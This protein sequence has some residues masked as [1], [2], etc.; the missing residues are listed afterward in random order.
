[1]SLIFLVPIEL[2][3]PGYAWVLFSG[4]NSRFGIAE[5]LALSF[6]ISVSFT[7][8]FTAGLSLVTSHYLSYSVGGSLGLSTIL[9]ILSF[10]HGN[11]FRRPLPK[12]DRTMLPVIATACI[13]VV[14]LTSLFWSSPFYPNTDAYDPIT[15]A[16]VVEGIIDGFGRTLLLHSN[17]AIGLHFVSAVLARLLAVDSL[18]AIRFLLSMVI[19]VSVFLTYFSARSLLGKGNAI[20][21]LIVAA[22]IIPADAIHF[23]RV[24]TF[25]NILADAVVVAMLWLIVSYTTEPNRALGLTLTFLAVAGL[26]VHSSFLMFIA[27]LWVALPVFLISYRRYFKN[28]FK[29][30]LFTTAG[31]FCLFVLLGSFLSASLE[32]I[33][34]GYVASS[35]SPTPV[36]LLL[37]VLVW[38][39]V[40]LAGPLA[41]VSIVAAVVFVVVKQR[42]A[43]W[44]IFGC[45]WFGLLVVAAFI[46]PEGWRFILLSLVPASFLLGD[47][48]GSLGKLRTLSACGSRLTARR[49]LLPILLCGLILSGSFVGLLP[50][51]FDPSSR[52]RE[53]AVVASMSW[54]KQ[55]GV[56]RSVASVELSLDYRY[57]T[58]LTGLAYVGDFNESANSMVVQTGGA[59][60]GYVAIAVQ[61]TQ[62]PT[63]ESSNM[64]VEKYQNSVVAIF[65]IPP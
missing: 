34:T 4:L 1:M 58:T 44:P 6:I 35:F 16:Q 45:I 52:S 23:I 53:E 27:A 22:F 55:N 61:G 37:Q 46:A 15:H 26:F 41:T 49:M 19:V 10:R 17:Y 33:F 13:Y 2:F 65:F 18:D 20:F 64:F 36:P 43:I 25:P 30:V 62:F 42:K 3:L 12:L 14:V 7:S 24:G 9:L 38:N 48:L 28:Y 29:S 31:L 56:G 32:R 54:L 8:L 47:S 63:F 21:A 50:R 59:K 39:Y 51:V 40:A 57:L 60:F 5:R 11:L